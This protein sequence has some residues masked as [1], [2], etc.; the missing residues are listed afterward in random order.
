MN[1]VRRTKLLGIANGLLFVA[2]TGVLSANDTQ[3]AIRT[4]PGLFNQRDTDTLGLPQLSCTLS[5]LYRASTSSFK[6]C[7][8]A[9]L[10]VFRDRLYACWSNGIDKEDH[11]G[12]VV[13]YCFTED[14]VNWSTP[15]VLAQDPDGALGDLGAVSA[16]FHTTSG[17][18]VAYYTAIASDHK[19]FGRDRLFA[20][21]STNGENWSKPKE[22]AAGFFIES[23][24]RLR[25]GRLLMNGQ[26]PNRQPRL[27]YSDTNDGVT[28]W[29]DA[30]IP[31]SNVFDW[32]EPSWFERR[33]GTIV[34]LFR[35]K[36]GPTTG[37]VL[38]ASI[39]KDNGVSWS[40]PAPTNYPDATARTHA[41]NLPNSTAYIINNPNHN[42]GGMRR[43]GQ[44][45]PLVIGLSS[46]GLLFD[47]AFVIRGENTSGRFG[48]KNKLDGWQYPASKVWKG[49]LFVAHSINKEDFGVTRIPLEAVE[50]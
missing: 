13:L 36:A 38:Y 6:F 17:T 15:L 22:L 11:D 10:A 27:R 37:A 1:S 19:T 5:I 20:I 33:D 48:G 50:P 16:G 46:D 26:F 24:R 28:G 49:H 39:S 32:P 41:G 35:T 12:Q 23:P 42:P 14:G 25:S 3:L 7:H 8:H 18:I 45:R 2:L 44:R 29:R 47:R 9:N 40:P 21:S 30:T 31:H 4:T 43:I 34:M